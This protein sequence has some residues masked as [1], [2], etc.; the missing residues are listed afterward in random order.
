[1]LHDI[2]M[3]LVMGFPMLIFTVFPALKLG[4]YLEEKHHISEHNKRIVMITTTI[5]VT[6]IL[7]SLLY[8]I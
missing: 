1:M 3:I 5:L 2:V 7:S 4:D 8:Y 6:L